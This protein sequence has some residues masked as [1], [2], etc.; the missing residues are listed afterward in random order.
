MCEF[1]NRGPG[2]CLLGGDFN[3]EVLEL[4][5]CELLSRAG[6]AGRNIKPTRQT[7]SS[8]KCRRKDQVWMSCEIQARLLEVHVGL[9]NGLK[10]HAFQKGVF[11]EGE[12]DRFQCWT[13]GGSGPEDKE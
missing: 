4:P 8:T 6:W 2:P 11:T 12:P 13:L 5:I 1:H 7:T 3:V 10:T 9:A